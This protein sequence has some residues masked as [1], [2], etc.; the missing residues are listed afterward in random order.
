MAGLFWLS[1]EA[2]R[3]LEPHLPRGEPGKPRVDDRMVVSGILHV[4]KVGRRWRD[5]PEAYGPATTN[6]N[7]YH[8]WS[9]R[10]IWQRIFEKIAASGPVPNELSIDSSHVK[11]HRSAQSSKGGTSDWNVGGGRTRKIHALADDQG[12]PAA[13]A[14]TPGNIADISM[15]IPLIQIIE[16]PKRLLAD[17]AYDAD[18]LP[19][20]LTP[21]R[22]LQSFHQPLSNGR[23]ILSIGQPASDAMSSSACSE[24]SK[25]G[26]G[27]KLDMIGSRQTASPHWRS[28]QS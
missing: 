8:C 27:S 11:A 19:T 16:P 14:L 25:T 20:G 9:Q 3:P 21:N 10:G 7:R 18:K 24:S 5:V 28:Y 23:L 15:A 6:Y 2:W 1:D 22:S 13:F 12:R 17:K 4:L 26:D